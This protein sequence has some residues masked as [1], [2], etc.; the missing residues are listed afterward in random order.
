M[1]WRRPTPRTAGARRGHAE[2]AR[3]RRPGAEDLQGAVTRARCEAIVVTLRCVFSC[4]FSGADLAMCI[5]SWLDADWIT[6]KCFCLIKWRA[7]ATA[8]LSETAA[9][10]SSRRPRVYVTVV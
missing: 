6:V 2:Q 3:G 4:R 1:G 10:L 5:F 8:R 9:P 7:N